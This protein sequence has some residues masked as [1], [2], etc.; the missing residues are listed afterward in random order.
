MSAPPRSARPGRPPL[1]AIW[2][3]DARGV[4][5]LDGSMPWHVRAEYAH[6]RE[7]TQGATVVMGRR[8]WEALPPRFRPLP[9]R[10]NVVVTRDAGYEAAGAEV[11]TSAVA[12]ASLP[13]DTGTTWVIGGA[14][15]YATLLPAT[16]V[17]VVTDLDLDVAAE[18]GLPLDDP[19]LTLAPDP[20]PR[21]REL[22]VEEVTALDPRLAGLRAWQD[23]GEAP[24]WRVRVLA[25]RA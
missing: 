22:T 14:A 24:R 17:L 19:R 16:D 23:D 5:G 6:F 21:F 25:H 3:Q 15:L 1:A 2:A 9:G 8:S 11:V 20:G 12:A 18:R 13:S 7:T 4:I 10:R